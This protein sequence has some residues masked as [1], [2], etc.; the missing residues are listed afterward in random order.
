MAKGRPP[1][2]P[3][4]K[5]I[6]TVELSRCPVCDSTEK[7]P[8][9]NKTELEYPGT[10]AAGEPYTHV[11]WRSTACKNCGQSRR[12]KTLENRVPDAPES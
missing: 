12:D 4:T 6:A 1:G 8:Y 10:T 2:T 7:T 3:N 9:G 5:E 11:V